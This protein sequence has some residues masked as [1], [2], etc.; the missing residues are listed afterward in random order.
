MAGQAVLIPYILVNKTNRYA[1]VTN[2]YRRLLD[3]RDQRH[4]FWFACAEDTPEFLEFAR[5]YNRLRN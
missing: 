5:K 3:Q 2:F 1:S 4:R